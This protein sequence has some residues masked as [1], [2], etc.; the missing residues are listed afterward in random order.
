ML[1]SRGPWLRNDLYNR[2][3]YNDCD[4]TL[5]FI[6]PTFIHGKSRRWL[7]NRAY[8]MNQHGMINKHFLG[9]YKNTDLQT[10]RGSFAG[11]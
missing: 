7:E 1:F 5:W 4:G 9:V 10:F 11:W 2:F 8:T 6:K 3:T